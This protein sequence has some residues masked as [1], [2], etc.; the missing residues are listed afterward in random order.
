MK[1]FGKISFENT[2]FDYLLFSKREL[3]FRGHDE[4]SDS[5][6]KGNYQEFSKAVREIDPVLD[7]HLQTSTVFRGTSAIIQNDIIQAVSNVMTT[8][9]NNKIEGAEFVSIMLD[10]PLT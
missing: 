10:E 3:A 7:N 9:I 4:S 1:K 5:L 6:N 2:D 8:E